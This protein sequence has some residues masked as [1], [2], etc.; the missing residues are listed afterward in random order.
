MKVVIQVHEVVGS[1][2][3]SPLNRLLLAGWVGLIWGLSNNI[4]E[5]RRTR[6]Q[7]ARD[8]EE[9]ETKDLEAVVRQLDGLVAK[10]GRLKFNMIS[11]PSNFA[12]PRA[13]S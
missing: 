10:Y 4:E 8:V 6:Q 11:K 3:Q 13:M 2:L 7:R 1:G 5:R 9:K 12:E